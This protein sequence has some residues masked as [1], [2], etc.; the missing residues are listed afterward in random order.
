MNMRVLIFMLLF[1]AVTC[2]RLPNRFD[3]LPQDLKLN[4]ARNFDIDL[5]G[6]EGMAQKLHYPGDSFLCRRD[7]KLSDANTQY[8]SM[9]SK[10]CCPGVAELP[11]CKDGLSKGHWGENSK[12]TN[13]WCTEKCKYRDLGSLQLEN[14]LKGKWIHFSGDSTMRFLYNR[15]VSVAGLRDFPK[16]IDSKQAPEGLEDL[17]EKTNGYRYDNPFSMTCQTGDNETITASYLFRG[18]IMH[19]RHPRKGMTPEDDV[20]NDIFKAWKQSKE[21]PDIFVFMIGAH[22]AKGWTGRPQADL[23]IDILKKDTEEFLSWFFN[24]LGFKGKTIFLKSHRMTEAKNIVQFYESAIS[25]MADMFKARGAMVGDF[26][27]TTIDKTNISTAGIHYNSMA[28]FHS[29][30]LLNLMC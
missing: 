24:D 15:F 23:D 17:N 21:M 18:K 7:F 8:V 14:C 3:S 10:D 19:Q 26:Y 30:I 4:T 16:D 20:H 5:L 1:F 2:L 22:E 11:I 6:P 25:T 13:S 29:N 12:C 9:P 27:Q 28:T